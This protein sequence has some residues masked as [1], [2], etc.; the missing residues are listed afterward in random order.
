MAKIL[1]DVKI[2]KVEP[3]NPNSP[4]GYYIGFKVKLTF[5]EAG[6]IFQ[7]VKNFFK[8]K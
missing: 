5:E 3:D 4:W 8:R 2:N 1:P 7:K 6:A